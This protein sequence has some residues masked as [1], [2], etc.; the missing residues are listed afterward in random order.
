MSTDFPRAEVCLWTDDVDRAYAELV[1]KGAQPLSS[2]HDFLGRLRA[3]WVA[4]PDGNP[5]EIVAEH[6]PEPSS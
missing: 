2:P 4:D 5:V 6:V 3:A 1:A